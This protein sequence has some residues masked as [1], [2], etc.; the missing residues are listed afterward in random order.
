MDEQILQQFIKY[1][2][3][4]AELHKLGYEKFRVCASIS[5][6]GAGYRCWLTVKQNSWKKCGVFC[7]IEDTELAILTHNCRLPWDYSDITPHENALRIIEEY[8]ELSRFALGRDP[9]YVEW[10]KLAL[11]EA[12]NG[13]FFYAFDEWYNALRLGYVPTA[14]DK[15][16][17]LPYPPAGDCDTETMY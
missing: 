2:E 13:R 5:P 3:T 14:G 9:E 15:E 7:D 17:G 16:H 6:N 11:E 1:F 12:R 4:I 10:F 8:R